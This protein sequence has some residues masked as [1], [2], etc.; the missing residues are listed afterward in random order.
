LLSLPNLKEFSRRIVE[1]YRK[2]GSHHLPWRNVKSPWGVLVASFLLRKT[3]VKQVERVYEEFM[4][5]Y[6]D[7]EAVC[8]ADEGEIKELLTPLGMEHR[9]SRLIKELAEEV[10]EK[11][12]G[13]IPLSR[14]ELKK[15]PGV[16][17]YISSEVL[18]VASGMPEPLLDRNMIRVIERVFGVKSSK[19]RPHT[20][21]N[22]WSFARTL[23]PRNPEEAK[24]FNYG[25]LDF[26][27]D[28]CQARKPRCGACFLADICIYY[29]KRGS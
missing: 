24:A 8:R 10:V 27:R 15:L 7:P 18:L 12:G 2:F 1:W 3:T 22:L 28:I 17:D 23:V 20:D 19:P 5:R 9:R 14:E 26:A 13:E 16:G 25:V 4:R 6:P 21:R 29:K 11:F